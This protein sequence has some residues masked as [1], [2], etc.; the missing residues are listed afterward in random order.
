MGN[1]SN[2][3]EDIMAFMMDRDSAR[4]PGTGPVETGWPEIE[5]S[6]FF[7]SH[8]QSEGLDSETREKELPR[9]EMNPFLRSFLTEMIPCIKNQLG[10][11]RNLTLF[12]TD[13]FEDAESRKTFRQGV[14]EKIRQ[15]DSVLNSLLNYININTPVIKAN[16]LHLILEEVLEANENQLREKNIKIFK[17]SEKDLPETFIHDEQVRFILN[18]VLQYAILSVPLNGT[19]GFLFRTSNLQGGENDQET[20]L[21]ND[22]EY[23]EAAVGFTGNSISTQSLETSPPVNLAQKERVADLILPLIEET[24]R[25]NQGMLKWEVNEKSKVLMVLRFPIERRKVIYYER[26]NL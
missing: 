21:E 6:S 12:P 22:G 4:E 13:R 1:G 17:R 25:K 3:K 7:S 11:I 24:L 19:I 16:T 26:I 15:I 14:T 9:K 23:I 18:S 2:P 5:E 10:A 20:S 8:L